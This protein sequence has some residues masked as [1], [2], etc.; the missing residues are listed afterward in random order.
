MSEHGVY[1]TLGDI[2]HLILE[3]HVSQVDLPDDFKK[4]LHVDNYRS[5]FQDDTAGILN[6]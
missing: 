2:P 3:V 1:G 4:Y 5:Q 6:L